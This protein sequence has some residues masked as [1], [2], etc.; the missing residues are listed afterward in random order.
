MNKIN[1]LN[2]INARVE[3]KEIYL[4]SGKDETEGANVGKIDSQGIYNTIFGSDELYDESNGILGLVLPTKE[5]LTIMFE[6][7]MGSSNF[8]MVCLWP[9]SLQFSR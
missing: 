7:P 3:A 4:D 6:N 1:F 2:G 8:A 9:H 5:V